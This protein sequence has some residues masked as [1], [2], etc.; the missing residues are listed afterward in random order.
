ML[1]EMNLSIEAFRRLKPLARKT[2]THIRII[3][4]CGLPSG[5]L[6]RTVGSAFA[7]GFVGGASLCS[8]FLFYLEY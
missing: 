2:G 7:A 3:K 6:F 5:F 1:Y 8:C 4:K